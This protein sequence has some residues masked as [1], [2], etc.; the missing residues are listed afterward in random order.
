MENQKS[1]SV[2]TLG[3]L[4]PLAMNLCINGL[5]TCYLPNIC[6]PLDV[7][8]PYHLD[9]D[10]AISRRKSRSRLCTVCIYIC[11]CVNNRYECKYTVFTLYLISCMLDKD[12]IGSK[13]CTLLTFL[14]FD[15]NILALY[16]ATCKISKGVKSGLI[17]ISY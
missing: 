5:Y 10:L 4:F 16:A 12:P 6:I 14:V 3:T 15:I 9:H 8:C 17:P 11:E 2:R 13:C 7:S 1:R